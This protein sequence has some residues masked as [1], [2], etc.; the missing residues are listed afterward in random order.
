MGKYYFEVETRE[1]V[2]LDA[3]GL[4]LADLEAARSEGARILGELVRDTL[5]GAEKAV[6]RM[7][8]RDDQNI[9]PF[10]LLLRFDVQTIK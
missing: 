5:P 4:E 9:E 1:G 2:F 7:T 3:D 8:V 6:V 10:L